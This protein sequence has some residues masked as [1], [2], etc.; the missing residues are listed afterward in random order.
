MYSYPMKSNPVEIHNFFYGTSPDPI[1]P[2]NEVTNKIE[3]VR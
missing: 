3:E 1:S 2:T